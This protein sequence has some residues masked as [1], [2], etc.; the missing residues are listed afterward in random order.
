MGSQLYYSWLPTSLV[1]TFFYY[2]EKVLSCI[3]SN[4]EA[5]RPAK[6]RSCD[7]VLNLCISPIPDI[8]TEPKP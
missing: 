3:A 8:M 5:S 7:G 4:L 2:P 1:P 6:A